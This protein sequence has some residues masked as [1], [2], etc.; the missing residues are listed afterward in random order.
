MVMHTEVESDI[1]GGVPISHFTVKRVDYPTV[2]NVSDIMSFLSKKGYDESL[3]SVNNLIKHHTVYV[4]EN[5]FNE[6]TGIIG[7]YTSYDKS[8]VVYFEVDNNKD[9]VMQKSLLNALLFNYTNSVPLYM[10]V[11]ANDLASDL[12]KM[13]LRRG[14]SVE[15]VTPTGDGVYVYTATAV[16]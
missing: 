10:T 11:C 9:T 7:V 3:S 5:E 4:A 12:R 2:G 16:V 14:F 8:D 1:L 6:I 13:L 15:L